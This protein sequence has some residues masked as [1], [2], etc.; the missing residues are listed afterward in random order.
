MNCSDCNLSQ[1][2]NKNQRLHL[3]C[4]SKHDEEFKKE[5]LDKNKF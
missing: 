4:C 5:Y 1:P 3:L 2:P